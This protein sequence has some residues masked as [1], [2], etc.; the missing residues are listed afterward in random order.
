MVT[1]NQI[2]LILTI[3]ITIGAVVTIVS[4]LATTGIVGGLESDIRSLSNQVDQQP[5]L[6]DLLAQLPVAPDPPPTGQNVTQEIIIEQPAGFTATDQDLISAFLDAIGVTVTE[7]FGITSQVN[8]IDA[9]FENQIESSFVKIQPLDPREVILPQAPD[10]ENIRFFINT[11]FSRQ[12]ADNGRNYHKFSGW[13]IVND[14]GGASSIPVTMTTTT[15]CGSI[16]N[17]GLCVQTVGS[18]N[19]DDKTANG[20]VL[21]GFTKTIDLSDWTRE[22][23]LVFNL[24]YNCN[25]FFY[26]GATQMRIIVSADMSS[27]TRFACADGHHTEEIS[28]LIGNSNS[29]TIQFGGQTNSVDK[30]RMD[31]KFNNAQVIGNSIIKRMAQ[32]TIS[33][34]DGLSIV[35]NN[36]DQTILDLGIIEVKLIGDT[37]FDNEK[38]V[39]TGDFETRINDATISQ[40]QLTANGFSQA[41]KIPI[42]IDGQD[43]FFFKLDEQFYGTDTFNKLTFI[44]N[45]MV[46][47]LGEGDELRTFEYHIPF[48]AYLLE[49]NVRP[50]EIVA[51]NEEDLAISVLKNDSTLITC[52]LSAGDINP[53]VLPPAVNVIANG[54]TLTTTNPDAG[55]GA[56]RDPLTG[57]IQKD[58]EFCQTVPNLPRNTEITYKIG[59]EFFE[60]FS[61]VTQANYFVKCTTNGCSS[62]IGYA[63]VTP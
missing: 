4:F 8:L 38:V 15:N 23:N 20:S 22:G 58:A 25:E 63:T 37:I 42:R 46:V 21:H 43:S 29:V 54:F 57:E 56:L 55:K 26:R 5:A 18:K 39:L 35:Q 44:V 32:E 24:D 41:N 49:F 53:E 12:L 62:N 7:T 27:E 13:D 45:N 11:D 30:F 10:V 47:N 36:Q 9:D 19:D 50:N 52:G 61:P 2:L 1:N 31:Y 60:V 51:F 59:N 6:E 14:F 34:I 3:P 40:H 17:T 16:P 28:D 48:V 33:L